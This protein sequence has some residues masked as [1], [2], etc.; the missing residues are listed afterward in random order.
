MV[1]RMIRIPKI[2]Q[3]ID[4]FLS[5]E[6]GRVSVQSVI[7]LTA[8]ATAI[9]LITAKLAHAQNDPQDAATA[10]PLDKP[11]PAHFHSH[12]SSPPGPP[13]ESAAALLFNS[14]SNATQ[15]PAEP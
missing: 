2:P 7:A 13:A 1:A 10:N 12:L 4:A 14:N 6:T 9:A 11:A 8:A 15:P 5:D 3:S